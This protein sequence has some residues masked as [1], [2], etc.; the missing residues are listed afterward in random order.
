[1]TSE[2]T[3]KVDPMQSPLWHYALSI[4]AE[5]D[6]APACL[7]LQEHAGVDVCVLLYSL[8]AANMGRK[9]TPAMLRAVDH[10][11]SDWREL[12]VLPLRKVRQNM[13]RE[14]IVIPSP[15]LDLIR[16]EVKQV[17]LHAE[18]VTLALL[19][20]DFTVQHAQHSSCQPIPPEVNATVSFYLKKNK[21][22]KQLMHEQVVQKAIATMQS[23]AR[24]TYFPILQKT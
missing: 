24:A 11:V 3:R 9:M 6:V 22:P 10:R 17:E 18:Q 8:Y 4:Y 7:V 23:K 2:P 20:L 16:Q 13:K 19:Y 12:V 15:L 14:T 1:M 21:L 5:P